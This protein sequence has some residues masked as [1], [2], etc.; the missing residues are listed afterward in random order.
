MYSLE[1]DKLIEKQENTLMEVITIV[2][3]DIRVNNTPKASRVDAH[4]D[5]N[6]AFL[7]TK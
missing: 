7:S 4:K 5:A 1:E 6:S 3:M 2:P